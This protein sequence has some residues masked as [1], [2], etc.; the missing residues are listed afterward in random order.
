[1]NASL[2]NADRNTHLKIVVMG[3][4]AAVMVAVLA[5]AAHFPGA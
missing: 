3:L 4:A 5:V 1:M 2:L